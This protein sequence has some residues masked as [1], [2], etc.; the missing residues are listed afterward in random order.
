MNAKKLRSLLENR[1]SKENNDYFLFT[2]VRVLFAEYEG[3]KITKRVEKILPQGWRYI[4]KEWLNED[5][6]SI[7]KIDTKEKFCLVNKSNTDIFSLENFDKLNTPYSVGSLERIEQLTSILNDEDKFNGYLKL[8]KL[9]AKLVKL[10][11]EITDVE[12]KPF[13]NN[14]SHY[15]VL[16]VIYNDVKDSYVKGNLRDALR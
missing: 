16:D 3:K 4:A 12:D 14:P 10:A 13:Y 8:Y 1:L 9:H 7:E 2:A 15:E 11:N 6:I 5:K